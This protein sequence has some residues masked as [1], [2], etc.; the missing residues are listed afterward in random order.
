MPLFTQ[1]ELEDIQGLLLS[2]WVHLRRSKYYFL[3]VLD[4][5]KAKQW[6]KDL[7]P[8]ITTA[9]NFPV[10]PAERAS[11][12][13]KVVNIAFTHAGVVALGL[14]EE[15]QYSFG[16][17]FIYGMAARKTVLGDKGVNAPENWVVG[18]PKNPEIHILLSLD[19]LDEAAMAELVKD[20]KTIIDVEG[21]DGVEIV[22]EE[23]GFRHPAEKE[24]FG[25]LDG[26][27][28]P[29][30]QR[31]PGY[32]E[33]IPNVCA[34]GEFILG[35]INEA[36]VYPPSP[37][38]NPEHDPNNILPTLPKETKQLAGKKDFGLRGSYIVYRKLY[39]DVAGFW[40]FMDGV[41]RNPDG[42][43]NIE[44]AVFLASKMVGRWPSGTPFA[45]S[46]D[47]DTPEIGK[48]E[49]RRDAFLYHADDAD[50]YKTP[51][52]SHIRRTNPRDSRF[53]E[54]DPT[55][56][57][58]SSDKHRL[59]RRTVFYGEKDIF[60]RENVEKLDIPENI[61]DDGNDRGSQFFALNA[62]IRSQFEFVQ[63]AWSNNEVFDGLKNS[64]DPIGGV[65]GTSFEIP[66]KPARILIKD[67]P[68][69]IQV[70]GG[71]YFFLPSMT[72]LRYLAETPASV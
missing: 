21:D 69:F 38:L 49:N 27:S 25:W 50:G 60:P 3:R 58:S 64:R 7:M 18:G 29:H 61:V 37:W 45:L 48:D 12:L 26:I 28:Q 36:G 32:P 33:D 35:Y 55:F 51:V 57:L 11:K 71:A 16:R 67:V 13:P 54:P 24:A 31:M 72:A 22:H 40:N 10:N 14:P 2:E 65:G 46:P 20:M 39:Q 8:F 17:E 68:Q 41:S 30:V 70:R 63:V 52:A 43:R 9:A 1:A 6:L 66:A 4:I 59:I 23:N 15:G 47:K 53:R 34:T 44:K 19:A 5:T 42:T 62:N 56:S